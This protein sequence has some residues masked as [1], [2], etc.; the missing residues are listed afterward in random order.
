MPSRCPLLP[1]PAFPAA[2]SAL[3]VGGVGAE[4]GP[5]LCSEGAWGQRQPLPRLPIHECSGG[6]I[7]S[8]I[9]RWSFLAAL[10]NNAL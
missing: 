7:Y 6:L 3:S 5:C 2:A 9:F 8:I 4:Q 10:W 1:Q